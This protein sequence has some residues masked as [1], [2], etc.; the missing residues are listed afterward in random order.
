MRSSLLHLTV[1]L[2]S[3]SVPFCV[4]TVSLQELAPLEMPSFT[5]ILFLS[6]C[7]RTLLF[8][9]QRVTQVLGEENACQG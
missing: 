6:S 2:P 8:G 4:K 1:S 9:I 5:L 7:L 3:L